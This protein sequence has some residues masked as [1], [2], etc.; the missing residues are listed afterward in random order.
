M[1][2]GV[3]DVRTGSRVWLDPGETGEYYIPRIYWTSRPDTLAVLTLNRPQNTLK[4][5]TSSTSRPAAAVS[6]SLETVGHLARRLS[7]STPASTDLMSFPA[8][9]PEEF[10][11]ISDRDGWQHIYRYDYA[12]KLLN[13]VT[14]GRWS[15]TRIEGIDAQRGA[16]YYTSTEASPLERQLYAI[17]FDGTG[18][19]RLTTTDW[20]ALD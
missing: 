20:D 5:C 2:I 10:F 15:V 18:E 17:G 9:R 19:R 7:T 11:W 13:Q 4:V 8:G 3:V 6:C 1:R 16:I 12:G 14:R